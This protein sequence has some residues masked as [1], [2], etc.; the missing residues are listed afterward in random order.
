MSSKFLPKSATKHFPLFVKTALKS[1]TSNQQE[2]FFDEYNIRA[3]S[4]PVAYLAHILLFTQYGYL[5][6]WC[7]QVLFWITLGGYGFWWV[8]ML[9]VIPSMVH[10][11]N[12]DIAINL[13]K[14]MKSI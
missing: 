11:Y 5:E 10:E 6:K 1:M 9:F 13:L 14:E 4:V 2:D 7:W 3:R 8:A 12:N